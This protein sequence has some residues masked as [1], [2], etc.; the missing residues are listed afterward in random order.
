MLDCLQ[1]PYQIPLLFYLSTQLEVVTTDFLREV[2]VSGDTMPL[3]KR[4]TIDQYLSEA[5]PECNMEA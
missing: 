5:A 2:S 1:N 4:E 3:Q